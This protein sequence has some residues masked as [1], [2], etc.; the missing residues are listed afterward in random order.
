MKSSKVYVGSISADLHHEGVAVRIMRDSGVTIGKR[1]DDTRSGEVTWD[2]C[3][4]TQKAL[5]KLDP[6]FGTLVWTL[7]PKED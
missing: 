3:T 4:V 7:V 5:K 6:H 2:N 1:D